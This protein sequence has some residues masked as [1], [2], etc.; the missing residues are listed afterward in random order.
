M[1][2]RGCL[3]AACRTNK[4][5]YGGSLFVY[6]NVFGSGGLCDTLEKSILFERSQWKE[7]C[8]VCRRG[9]E[10]V[11]IICNGETPWGAHLRPHDCRLESNIALTKRSAFWWFSK[12]NFAR[13]SNLCVGVKTKEG[14]TEVANSVHFRLVSLRYVNCCVLN[15]T[16][17]RA[18]KRVCVFRLWNNTLVNQESWKRMLWQGRCKD[19]FGAC[20]VIFWVRSG[21]CGPHRFAKKKSAVYT[22]ASTRKR[23]FAASC[24]VAEDEA[25]CVS[26]C[27]PVTSPLSPVYR[28][29]EGL[30][31]HKRDTRQSSIQALFML[32]LLFLTNV[33]LIPDAH[34]ALHALHEL[35]HNFQ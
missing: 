34:R 22:S 8:H 23:S 2:A 26:K 32:F 17:T 9:R 4:G 5:L 15:R 30:P 24:F 25:F 19:L 33:L 31:W 20:R 3:E 7:I 27:Q 13:L 10:C 12:Q 21:I 11:H 28:S 14:I 6:L 35:E 29:S 1:V 16:L 18:R